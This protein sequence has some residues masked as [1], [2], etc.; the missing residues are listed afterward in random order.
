MIQTMKEM[1]KEKRD[2]GQ[3][4][5]IV[6]FGG[7]G[8]NVG[9]VWGVINRRKGERLWKSCLAFSGVKVWNGME[10]STPWVDSSV[11]LRTHTYEL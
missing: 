4:W 2:I 8:L 6:R 11:A 9:L 1:L 5:N 7:H 10:I 3:G